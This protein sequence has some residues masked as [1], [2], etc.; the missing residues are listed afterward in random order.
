MIESLNNFEY[1]KISLG[2]LDTTKHN[3][4]L[5]TYRKDGWILFQSSPDPRSMNFE[6]NLKRM[7]NQEVGSS[8]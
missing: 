5:D 8:K 3:D 1:K 7:V 4:C 2:G 6:Y